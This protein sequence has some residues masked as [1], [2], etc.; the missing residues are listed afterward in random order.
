ES[1][2][3]RS[4]VI[5]YFRNTGIPM[6]FATTILLGF[7]VGVAIAGQTFYSFILE[8]LRNIGALKAMGASDWLLTRMV[9]L[10]SFTVGLIGYGMGIGLTVL[11]GLLVLK[12]GMPPFAL[13]YQLPL[14]TLIVIMF[15]CA[16]A[17]V[18]GILKIRKLEPAIVFRG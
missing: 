18:L 10:Q 11:F 16:F 3:A 8:N 13:P 17:A 4:T 2:F 7:I 9:L 6:S 14:F 15:I 1:Q 12:K 5:W